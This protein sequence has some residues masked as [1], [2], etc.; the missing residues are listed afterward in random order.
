MAYFVDELGE[1]LAKTMLG[2]WYFWQERFEQMVASPTGW[3][4][5]STTSRLRKKGKPNR[6]SSSGRPWRPGPILP[7]PG[8]A[9]RPNGNGESVHRH[10]FVS[11]IRREGF[12]KG[13][14]GGGDWPAPGSVEVLYRG[15]YDYN[16]PYDVKI[17]ASLRMTADL[18]DADKVLAV[19]PGGIAGR[20]FHPHAK[21][22][23]PAFMEGERFTGGS[24]T[25]RSKTM[26][27]R[28][29]LMLTPPK[30]C[31]HFLTLGAIQKSQKFRLSFWD[32]LIIEAAITGGADVLFT[33]DLQHGQAIEQ[34]KI[35]NP[36]ADSTP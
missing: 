8:E 21:D 1:D 3:I 26:H 34:L 24:A 23:I 16:A 35:Q 36:F 30:K 22:Q 32:A 7:R 5:G 17:S 20:L 10:T 14:L 13:L 25:G 4:T 19:L 12:G 28:N 31:V 29:T 15:I 11:P 33:E 18:A 27:N 6:T 2:T 9:I